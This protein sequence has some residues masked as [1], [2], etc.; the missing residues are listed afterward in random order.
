MAVSFTDREL[1][2]TNDNDKAKQ[3]QQQSWGQGWANRE[4]CVKGWWG[5]NKHKFARENLLSII[6]TLN[7]LLH[8]LKIP[9]SQCSKNSQSTNYDKPNIIP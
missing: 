7:N 4:V 8:P 1:Q 3:K 5:Q 6:Q 9:K 2:W